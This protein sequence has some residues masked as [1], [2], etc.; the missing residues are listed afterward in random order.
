MP[1]YEYFGTAEPDEPDEA[2]FWAAM[3]TTSV[4]QHCATCHAPSP[5]WLHPLD[6]GRAA[7]RAWGKGYTLP[8]AWCLC[9]SC[10]ALYQAGDDE[11]LIAVMAAKARVED[12]VVDGRVGEYDVVEE[13]F[14]KPVRVLRRADLGARPL[15]H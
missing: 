8:M 15:P 14:R 10:E 9:D 11:A 1:D 6:E 12:Q 13:E 7:Y 5:S 2:A 3:P 4:D